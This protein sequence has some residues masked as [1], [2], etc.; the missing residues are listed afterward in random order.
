MPARRRTASTPSSS[1]GECAGASSRFSSILRAKHQERAP[2]IARTLEGFGDLQIG[3]VPVLP[4]H[5]YAATRRRAV[6]C[7]RRAGCGID[8][9]DLSVVREGIELRTRELLDAGRNVVARLAEYRPAMVAEYLR[10]IEGAAEEASAVAALFRHQQRREGR[11]RVTSS[12][13]RGGQRQGLTA[14]ESAFDLVEIDAP[15][16]GRGWR[17]AGTEVPGCAEAINTMAEG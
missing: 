3:R 5:A 16:T 9:V 7:R 12:D 15:V 17:V 11:L 13:R 14:D 6:L 10:G 1:A 2:V 4:R 8:V